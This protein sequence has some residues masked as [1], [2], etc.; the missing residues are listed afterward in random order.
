MRE[1]EKSFQGSKEPV[2]DWHRHSCGKQPPGHF[3]RDAA[4]V[5][6]SLRGLA[7][8]GQRA[9]CCT[10]VLYTKSVLVE[11]T[12]PTSLPIEDSSSVCHSQGSTC[13][14]RRSPLVARTGTR[15]E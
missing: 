7:L 6:Q 14:L 11:Q 2:A 1:F 15:R 9:L 5:L 13:S 3:T 12:T 4:T 8:S 10:Q